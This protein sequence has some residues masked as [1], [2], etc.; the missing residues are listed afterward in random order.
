MKNFNYKDML[1]Q[2]NLEQ[3]TKFELSDFCENEAFGYFLGR[4]NDSIQNRKILAQKIK[5]YIL[6]NKV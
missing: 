2:Y 4:R 1:D 3:P 5:E 6:T